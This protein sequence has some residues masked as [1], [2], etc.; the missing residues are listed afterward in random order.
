MEQ[1]FGL[2][3]SVDSQHSFGNLAAVSLLCLVFSCNS[4]SRRLRCVAGPD[5]AAK[6]TAGDR[7]SRIRNDLFTEC[8]SHSMEFLVPLSF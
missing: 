8:R 1:K 7:H 2:I 6:E 4:F 3:S 5:K